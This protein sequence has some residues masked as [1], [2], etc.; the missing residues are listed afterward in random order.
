MAK[1]IVFV[2]LRNA[3][4]L[5]KFLGPSGLNIKTRLMGLVLAAVSM[6]FII[7]GIGSV[8][9]ELVAAMNAPLRP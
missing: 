5:Q 9:P 6:Q 4:R 3:A 1:V 7:R 8:L 2:M